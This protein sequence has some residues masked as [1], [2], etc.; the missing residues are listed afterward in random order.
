MDL[1]TEHRQHELD[2]A[3]VQKAMEQFTMKFILHEDVFR[4]MP[5]LYLYKMILWKSP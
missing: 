1:I 2:E 4:R 3:V 5:L